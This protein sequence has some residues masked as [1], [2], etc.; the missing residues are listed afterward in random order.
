MGKIIQKGDIISNNQRWTRRSL[1]QFTSLAGLLRTPVR[2]PTDQV[3]RKNITK[4]STECS[5]LPL[6]LTLMEN[7]EMAFVCLYKNKTCLPVTSHFIPQT[8]LHKARRYW[9][10][11]LHF[12]LL[13]WE[14]TWLVKYFWV[15]NDKIFLNA[16]A[17]LESVIQILKTCRRFKLQSSVQVKDPDCTLFWHHSCLNV[18]VTSPWSWHVNIQNYPVRHRRAFFC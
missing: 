6:Q 4:N 16:L 1:K 18:I 5:S 9:F 13:P 11:F 3:L 7:E 12:T 10:M 14:S 17:T 8:V 15:I 2:R